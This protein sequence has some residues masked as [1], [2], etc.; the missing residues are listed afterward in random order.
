MTKV[1]YTLEI[2]APWMNTW[3]KLSRSFSMQRRVITLIKK[4]YLAI[5]GSAYRRKNTNPLLRGKPIFFG[6][7]RQN[8]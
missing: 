7:V 5:Q 1:D 3:A 6:W 8:P 2:R 4:S